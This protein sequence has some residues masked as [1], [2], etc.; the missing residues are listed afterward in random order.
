MPRQNIP[1][2]GNTSYNNDY[3]KHP[4]RARSAAPAKAPRGM[5]APFDGAS[6]YNTDFQK[7][8]TPRAGPA[9]PIP[10]T[11]RPD[12]GAFEGIPEYKREYVK[13]PLEEK[14]LVHLEPEIRRFRTASLD[15]T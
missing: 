15:R 5:P 13:H 4:I 12:T 8:N 1:F 11:L 6:T 2:D 10:A 3:V 9:K 14:V 7:Y